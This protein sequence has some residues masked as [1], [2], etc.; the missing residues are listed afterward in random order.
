MDRITTTPGLIHIAEQIF[1]NLDRKSL[2]ICQKVNE[3]WAS[4]LRNPYFWLN[5]M[6]QNTT[7]SQEHQKEWMRFG[8]KL[9]K[10]NLAK[11]MTPSLNYIY[12][13]LD[14][15]VTIE[16]T[17]WD[18]IMSNGDLSHL[19]S[20]EI[21][22]IMASLIEN[23]NAPRED[24]NTP[25]NWVAQNGCTEIVKILAPMTHNPNVPDQS[26]M[27]PIHWAACNGHTEIVKL[28]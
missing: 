24:G 1:S 16:K 6:T 3:N 20:G 18:A 19:S 2:F 11:D 8:E 5:R 7:L 4:I 12:G 17:Y 23:P 21:V 25:I 28:S 9:S 26:G 22:R 27:T 15:S 13:Q 14:D 10:L